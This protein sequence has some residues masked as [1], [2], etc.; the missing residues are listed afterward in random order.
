MR[1]M[2]LLFKFLV[3]CD[4]VF[5]ICLNDDIVF[6]KRSFYH[7]ILPFNFFKWKASLIYLVNRRMQFLFVIT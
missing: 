7:Y 5:L 1:N 6:H 2:T 4:L 3:L